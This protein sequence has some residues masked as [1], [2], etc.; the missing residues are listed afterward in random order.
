MDWHLFIVIM[1]TIILF[2]ECFLPIKNQSL[3]S[4][5]WISVLIVNWS[6][7][8]SDIVL[9]AFWIIHLIIALVVY[10]RNVKKNKKQ[11]ES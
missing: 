3:Y 7:H 8:W 4:V 6:N 1:G 11:K 5:L 10:I 9:L 2:G